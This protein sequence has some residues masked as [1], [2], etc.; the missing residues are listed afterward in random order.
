MF[1][2]DGRIPL[3]EFFAEKP[4][5]SCGAVA[6]FIGIVRNHDHGR[7]VLKLDYECYRP[8]AEK[9]IGR[10]VER[11]KCLWP[12]EGIQTLHRIGSLEIGEAAI[13]VRVNSARRADAFSACRFVVDEIKRTAPI[14]K[15]EYYADGTSEWVLCG[16]ADPAAVK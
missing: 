15:K 11:A 3:E 2:T 4:A 13:A 14:W 16:H 1:I 7:A 12:V 5:P 9:E 10:I 6:A 8:M